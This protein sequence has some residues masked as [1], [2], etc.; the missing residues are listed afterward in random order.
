MPPVSV[1]PN[2]AFLAAERKLYH[3]FYSAV[4]Q[5]AIAYGID[6]DNVP[7][8]EPFA[9]SGFRGGPTGPCVLVVC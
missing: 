5:I 3:I 1:A 2:I 6:F 9:P 8:Q 7:A 4:I